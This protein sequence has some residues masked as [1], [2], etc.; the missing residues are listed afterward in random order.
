MNNRPVKMNTGDTRLP[1]L[2]SVHLLR[3]LETT[4]SVSSEITVPL[5]SAKDAPMMSTGKKFYPVCFKQLPF[6]KKKI[7]H[8]KCLLV[9]PW[10]RISFKIILARGSRWHLYFRLKTGV[11]S[12][13]NF[14]CVINDSLH[15]EK[16][17]SYS[18]RG[19][20]IWLSSERPQNNRTLKL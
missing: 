5:I 19:L 17:S 11:R 16:N 3:S 8:S 12:G 9:S 1:Y 7:M 15:M 20:C 10:F 18:R 2:Y 4:L 14:K 13:I 6:R